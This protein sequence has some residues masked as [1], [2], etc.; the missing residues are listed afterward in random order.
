MVCD[1]AEGDACDA[2]AADAATAP[3]PAMEEKVEVV[4]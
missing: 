4:A 2:G 1:S 3:P